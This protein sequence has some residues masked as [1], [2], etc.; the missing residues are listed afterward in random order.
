MAKSEFLPV[1]RP[2]DGTG[3]NCTFECVPNSKRPRAIYVVFDGQRIAER[4]RGITGKPAWLSLV[5][6][7]KVVDVTRDQIAVFFGGERLH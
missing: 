7:Y 4:G 1:S 6:G 5:S 2:D 3:H